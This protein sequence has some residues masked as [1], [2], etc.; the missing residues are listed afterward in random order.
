MGSEE[1]ER[2]QKHLFAEEVEGYTAAVRVDAMFPKVNA[3]PGAEG[4]S[5]ALVR[6]AEI[7]GG[8]GG[9]D[10]GRH[11]VIAFGSVLEDGIAIGC[12]AREDAF[13]VAADLGVGIFLN[14][15]GRGSVLE[16]QG[17]DA[18]LETRLLEDGADMVG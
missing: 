1:Q 9:A 3:L 16:M 8:E 6:N 18:C 17:G 4:E 13:K 11:I 2:G 10:V 14:K 15:E 12:E 5:T 7:Y